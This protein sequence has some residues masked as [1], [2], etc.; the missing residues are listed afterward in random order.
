MLR[1]GDPDFDVFVGTV[2]QWQCWDPEAYKTGRVEHMEPELNQLV[3]E[4]AKNDQKAA[5]AF[6]SRVLD[7][8]TQAME[9]NIANSAKTGSTITQSI[10][11]DGNLVNSARMSTQEETLRKTRGDDIRPSDIYSEMFEGNDD[12][13]VKKNT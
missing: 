3:H 8:K 2:G 11:K 12:M 5:E 4:K 7:A 1:E 13:V 6:N 9:D 10:D